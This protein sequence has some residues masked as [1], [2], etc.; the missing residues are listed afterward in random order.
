MIMK[1]VQY[2]CDRCGIESE[3]MQDQKVPEKWGCVR[4][5]DLCPVCRTEAKVPRSNGDIKSPWKEGNTFRY[6]E[7][8]RRGRVFAGLF[9]DSGLGMGGYYSIDG[10][11]YWCSKSE[12]VQFAKEDGVE[13]ICEDTARYTS[14]GYGSARYDEKEKELIQKVT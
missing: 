4:K 14:Y 8:E 7:Y 13:W 5:N 1:K 2:V 6:V 11:C 10:W 12:S 3:V 9:L